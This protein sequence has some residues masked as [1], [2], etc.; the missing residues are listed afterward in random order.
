MLIKDLGYLTMI[1]ETISYDKE[2]N[3]E[4]S[5]AVEKGEKGLTTST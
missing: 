2:E 3:T 1:L 5:R 4:Q